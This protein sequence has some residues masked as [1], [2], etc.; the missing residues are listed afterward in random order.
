M[1]LTVAPNGD[2][3]CVTRMEMC[4]DHPR[5]GSTAGTMLFVSKDNGFTWSEAREI[6]DSSVTPHILTL[7]NRVVLL[8]YGRPGVHFRY[9]LDNGETFSEPVSIIGKALEQELA[10]GAGYMECKYGNSCSYSNTFAEVLEDDT[11]LVLF[12]DLKY[13]E[14]GDAQ[15]HKAAFVAHLKCVDEN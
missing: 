10:D 1:F 13:R 14:P 3:L 6:A 2:L 9:S 4:L 15:C 7:K 5:S 12:N 11:V 8:I